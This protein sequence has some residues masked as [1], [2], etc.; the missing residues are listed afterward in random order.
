MFLHSD[1]WRDFQ[2]RAGVTVCSLEDANSAWA[3]R[4]ELPYG[5]HYWYSPYAQS[6][7]SLIERGKES[8]AVFVK[9][10]PMQEDNAVYAGL[11][12][13]GFVRSIKSLQPQKT[14]IVSLSQD[15]E[16]ML[17]GMSKKARY[18]IRLASRKGVVS[19]TDGTIDEFWSLMKETTERDQFHAHNRSYYEELLKT[20]GVS[21]YIARVGQVPAACAI[22]LVHKDRGVYLHGASSYEHR[23]S[24]ASSGLQWHIMMSLADE[25]VKEYDLWGI[26]D[27]RYPGVTWFKRKFGGT[28]VEYGG[29]YD[30]VLRP[31]LYNLYRIKQK[32][33]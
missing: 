29:S 31:V 13:S 20:Q 15:H 1:L 22:V 19:D 8:G 27:K 10:E 18:N 30:F 23:S 28:E 21:L 32:V 5:L 12:D 2:E 4:I 9:C 16:V 14:S 33:L 3:L 11:E 6:H 25:G 24:M 7:E 17:S 26:D